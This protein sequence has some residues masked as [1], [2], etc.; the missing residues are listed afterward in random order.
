MRMRKKFLQPMFPAL[1]A[2]SLV[3][4]GCEDEEKK[5]ALGEAE[6]AR[7][8]LVRVKAQL[9]RAQREITDLTDALETVKKDRDE[10][11]KQVDRLTTDRGSAPAASEEA[12]QAA[13]NL[14]TRT[15]E[16][17]ASAAAFQKQ[18]TDL[19]SLIEAQERTIAEQE[20]TIGE[21]LKTI[22]LLEGSTE[23]PQDDAPGQTEAN[24]SRL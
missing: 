8:E 1:L 21:L 3:L 22:E 19:S 5:K 23:V 10:L 16:Q 7:T 24:D 12:K 13:R 18:I 17:D 4:A 15:S 2:L 14:G 6:K 20:A 11:A 9:T